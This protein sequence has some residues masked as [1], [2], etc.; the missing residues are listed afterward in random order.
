MLKRPTKWSSRV[1]LWI[2]FTNTNKRYELYK[3][4]SN[5]ETVCRIN[6]F[7]NVGVETGR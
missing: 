3:I 6:R 5:N 2:K 7:D 1:G 4:I